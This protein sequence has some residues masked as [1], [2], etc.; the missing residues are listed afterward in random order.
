MQHRLVSS[1]PVERVGN[2]AAML[3]PAPTTAG[4]GDRKTLR[5][6]DRSC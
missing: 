3:V 1:G 5:R 6:G 4:E 2:D